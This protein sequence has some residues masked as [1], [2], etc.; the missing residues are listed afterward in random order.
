[1][2]ASISGKVTVPVCDNKYYKP[3][4]NVQGYY[5]LDRDHTWV[6]SGSLGAAYANGF[7]GKNLPFYQFYTAGGI[8][9]LRDLLM[10]R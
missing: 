9:S 10:V 7:G 2:K 5:P 6:I 8:G 3:S 1:M 4:T